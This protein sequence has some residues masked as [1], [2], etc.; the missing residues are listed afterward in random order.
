MDVDYETILVGQ[1]LPNW[2]GFFAFSDLQSSCYTL[3]STSSLKN[4]T[5]I[6]KANFLEVNFTNQ[7]AAFFG[8]QY[9]QI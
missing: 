9:L 8:N 2:C 3:I 5:A 4:I 1:I 7:T 6:S